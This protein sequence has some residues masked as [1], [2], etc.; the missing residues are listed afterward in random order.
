MLYQLTAQL[1]PLSIIGNHLAWKSN[2]NQSFELFSHKWISY[3]LIRDMHN[4]NI[5]TTPLLG[6]LQVCTSQH[7]ILGFG[8]SENCAFPLVSRRKE[9][10]RWGKRACLMPHM[11]A[12]QF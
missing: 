7:I 4:L 2:C 6:A 1:S 9:K 12:D 8:M 3:L 10:R 5:S 11:Q